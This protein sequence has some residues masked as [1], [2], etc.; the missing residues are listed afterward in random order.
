[1]IDYASIMSRKEEFAVRIFLDV[2]AT[3][4]QV[5]KKIRGI[6]DDYIH[7]VKKEE[8][9]KLTGPK[10]QGI[11][12]I[13]TL[14]DVRIDGLIDSNLFEDLNYG[15]GYMVFLNPRH[16]KEAE[17]L[18]T[19]TA[20]QLLKEFREMFHTQ[21]SLS[22]LEPGYLEGEACALYN[23]LSVYVLFY[24][25]VRLAQPKKLGPEDGDVFTVMEPELDKLKIKAF[26]TYVRILH[27]KYAQSKHKSV[28]EE[29]TKKNTEELGPKEIP[30]M[31]YH[32]LIRKVTT[33]RLSSLKFWTRC[34]VDDSERKIYLVFKM[35]QTKL[36]EIAQDENLKKEIEVANLDIYSF[37]PMD[38]LF[39]P[40]FLK[41]IQFDG[42]TNRE[43][44]MKPENVEVES[45]QMSDPKGI[46]RRILELRRLNKVEFLA[47]CRDSV[48]R[49]KD[50]LRKIF[51]QFNMATD[52][53]SSEEVLQDL[54][55]K[56]ENWE[57][58]MLF[59]GAIE[60]WNQ[61]LEKLKGDS[62]FKDHVGLMTRMIFLK[63]LEDTNKVVR[64]IR[65]SWLDKV[66]P[67]SFFAKDYEVKNMWSHL[68]SSYV[69]PYL[70]FNTRKKYQKMWRTYEI[71]ELGGRSVFTSQERVHLA[72]STIEHSM[73]PRK[74]LKNGLM[75]EIHPL[76]TNFILKGDL[77]LPLFQDISFGV[78]HKESKEMNFTFRQETPVEG[79]FRELNTV[80]CFK[81]DFSQCSLVESFKF[82]FS[83]C[84][85][86]PFDQIKN[87]FGEKISMYFQ[88][89]NFYTRGLRGI[90]ILTCCL[91]L[92]RLFWKGRED[93]NAGTH[94]WILVIQS[95]VIMVWNSLF[96]EQW[97]KKE[98][99]VGLQ[100][101]HIELEEKL[102]ER[103]GYEAGLYRD[104]GTGN[105]NFSSDEK[106]KRAMRM[107]VSLVIILVLLTGSVGTVLLLL[108][109]KLYLR[110]SDVGEALVIGL[111]IVLN[112]V[113]IEIFELLYTRLSIKSNSFEHH[114]YGNTYELSLIMKRFLFS[115]VNYFNSFFIIAF[116]KNQNTGVDFLDEC[117]T[118][119]AVE[120]LAC[121][122]ELSDQ[123]GTIFIF[124]LIQNVL[125]VIFSVLQLV[126]K[127][128][129]HQIK[130]RDYPWGRIDMIILREHQLKNY[131][132]SA[133]I[134]GLL[135]EYTTT[136]FQFSCLSLFGIAFPFSFILS[137]CYNIFEA[138][139]D[140][141]KLF[142]LTKR[143][144]P[145]LAA[146]IGTWI[147]IIEVISFISIVT[148][149]GI[150]IYTA[151]AFDIESRS[152]EDTSRSR[153]G[154]FIALILAFSILKKVAGLLTS[155]SFASFKTILKR[156]S[157]LLSKFLREN[158][159]G[160][161]GSVAKSCPYMDYPNSLQEYQWSKD[162]KLLTEEEELRLFKPKP[163]VKKPL[164]LL[165]SAI[166]EQT[167][168][169][170]L[171]YMPR[172]V[173]TKKTKT[174][175]QKIDLCSRDSFYRS[176]QE[177]RGSQQNT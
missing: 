90:S 106:C 49:H 169:D 105:W 75:D 42:L 91:E 151:R 66:P 168:D 86:V 167:A 45:W 70:P 114:K 79:L 17:K 132:D 93:Y 142:H 4:S 124:L 110:R 92:L 115:F 72:F 77:Q 68:K 28:L 113:Q 67:F 120:K 51:Q 161:Q 159:Q 173:K 148:N 55:L 1:M 137:F 15:D 9:E 30:R 85:T 40:F 175:N 108:Y 11:V 153:V 44:L 14:G 22:Q 98:L 127:K 59:L 128:V 39:R 5:L 119:R 7:K 64:S 50:I 135:A 176:T 6:F 8:M 111:P 18:K 47:F 80:S 147:R 20:G 131:D 3:N 13:D 23:L 100:S 101:G 60:T 121:L 150:L 154:S 165:K 99:M 163:A 52:F 62:Q 177:I 82:S 89:L 160:S 83:N 73:N 34:F 152:K 63:A 38:P 32:E 2:F 174:S 157:I 122:G 141:A 26:G 36:E 103:Q 112:F 54:V 76:H 24:E 96:I 41:T 109:L 81:L 138:H 53:H 27:R 56:R 19:I 10:V 48:Q 97:K 170:L 171:S 139:M 102:V 125:K 88:F 95:L 155:S 107:M 166:K 71:N 123:F 74:L 12:E 33:L 78:N 16:L 104:T 58:F 116:M 69:N 145:K 130:P 133:E 118:Y 162:K 149:A 57:D 140:K 61:K 29:P 129:R 143:P 126:Y 65:G 25:E 164:V 37:L 117:I 136:V 134:D 158:S 94:H 31:F 43:K 172:E 21:A 46:S 35:T 144:L 84:L 87:Y 156:Q 146:S